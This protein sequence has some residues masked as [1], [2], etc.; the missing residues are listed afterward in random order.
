M[1][2]ARANQTY[3]SGVTVNMGEPQL[4]RLQKVMAHAGVASRRKCEAIIQAGR[5]TVNGEVV[6][7]LGTKVDRERDL[8]AVDDT[9]IYVDS[10]H[11]YIMLHKPAGVVSTLDDPRGRATIRE[12]VDVDAR[13]Y[14]AGRLDLDS[15][16]LVL[17]T[18]DG[19]LTY[20]LT[21]PSYEHKK[22]YHVLVTGR[23]P[24]SALERLRS[25]VRLE[26]GVLG[27]EPTAPAEV[28]VLR[29]DKDGTW[30]RV[31]L[32]EGRKRQ[33]RRMADAVGYPVKRLMR[34]RIGTLR[35][36]SLDPGA[37]RHLSHQEVDELR[38]SV[39]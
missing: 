38:A 30:L 6:T 21:H 25:G 37:W 26:D 7:E 35:L 13:V 5:V 28:D 39:L 4:Q 11:T 36:G 29:Q 33:I 31:V 17:L 16:G 3:S 32:H 19:E 12:L 10:S 27:S 8:I 1:S 18:D 20:R 2:A 23:P 34:V 24:R 14:P 22:E 15:E 9:P